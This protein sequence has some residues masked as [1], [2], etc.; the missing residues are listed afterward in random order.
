MLLAKHRY[1]PLHDKTYIVL[2]CFFTFAKLRI[3]DNTKDEYQ[4]NR[5][6]KC[7]GYII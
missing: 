7:T 3:D 1:Y 6:L 5:L 4:K 2:I